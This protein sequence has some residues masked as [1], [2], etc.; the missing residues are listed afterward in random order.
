MVK[1]MQN[2][3]AISSLASLSFCKTRSFTAKGLSNLMFNCWK[4]KSRNSNPSRRRNH[5]LPRIFLKIFLNFEL[6]DSS[7]LLPPPPP[8]F[9]P[10]SPTFLP[11]WPVLAP[12]FP[13]PQDLP[14]GPGAIFQPPGRSKTNKERLLKLPPTYRYRYTLSEVIS[15]FSKGNPASDKVY[16][17][18]GSRLFRCL[19]QPRHDP[20]AKPDHA[21]SGQGMPR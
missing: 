18:L 13:L 9:S 7:H 16:P 17:Y 11:S 12:P 4:H 15:H 1:F 20:Q 5:W 14:L 21:N 6:P 8:L 2:T 10:T 3:P 19:F